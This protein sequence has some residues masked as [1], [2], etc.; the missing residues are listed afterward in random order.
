MLPIADVFAGLEGKK[1]SPFNQLK[2][3]KRIITNTMKKLLRLPIFIVPDP[4]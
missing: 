3:D 4:L 2:T 1:M